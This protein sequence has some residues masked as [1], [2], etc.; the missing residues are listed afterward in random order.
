M[1]IEALVLVVILQKPQA[2][3]S[4]YAIAIHQQQLDAGCA[5]LY[6]GEILHDLSKSKTRFQNIFHFSFHI[7]HLPFTEG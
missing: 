4:E 1:G 3:V 5:A 7:S 2:P 6:R